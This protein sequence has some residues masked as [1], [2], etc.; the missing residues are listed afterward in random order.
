M[1]STMGIPSASLS[2]GHPPTSL[3]RFLSSKTS[4]T[5]SQN[6]GVMADELGRPS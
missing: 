6:S 3:K 2:A 5:A 4:K 1:T